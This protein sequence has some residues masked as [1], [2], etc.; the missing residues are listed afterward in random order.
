LSILHKD[1]GY[2]IPPIKGAIREVI[3][4]GDFFRF[5][6]PLLHPF[7]DF[8]GSSPAEDL[9][10]FRLFSMRIILDIFVL[11]QELNVGKQ[12][13]LPQNISYLFLNGNSTLKYSQLNF[14]LPFLALMGN[15]W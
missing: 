5:K 11:C 9:V 12:S 14:I 1:I 6:P 4:N 3:R 13:F 10:I 2:N 7:V 8:R 15:T